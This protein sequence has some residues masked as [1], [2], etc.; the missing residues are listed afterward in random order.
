MSSIY[1]YIV[2]RVLFT[3]AVWSAARRKR[4]IQRCSENTYTEK[5][6][7]KSEKVVKVSTLTIT[8][9]Q[10]LTRNTQN[11]KRF[12]GSLQNAYYRERDHHISSRRYPPVRCTL[13]A[14]NPTPTEADF[15]FIKGV[16]V[17]LLN[18]ASLVDDGKHS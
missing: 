11:P 7:I 4:R 9:G 17:T 12:G 18:F 1:I 16:L 13:R 2:I 5:I 3:S 15:F 8:G 10:Y 6:S 14:G